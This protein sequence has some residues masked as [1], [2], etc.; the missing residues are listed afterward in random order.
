MDLG[1]EQGDD[2]IFVRGQGFVNLSRI[3]LEP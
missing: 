2:N 1:D 3:K